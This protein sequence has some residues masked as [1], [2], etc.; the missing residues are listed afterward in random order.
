MMLMV[1]SADAS[2]L[3]IETWYEGFSVVENPSY[4]GTFLSW[5]ATLDGIFVFVAGVYIDGVFVS[6][7]VIYWY[8]ACAYTP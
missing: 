6:S 1:T 2:Y 7:E 4:F 5:Q 8:N 3:Y